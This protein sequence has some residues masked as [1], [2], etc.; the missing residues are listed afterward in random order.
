MPNKLL[1]Q[2]ARSRALD[3]V[4]DAVV[5]TD[6]AGMII[7][8][9]KGSEKL[10]GYSSEEA[11]GQPVSMLHV[12]GDTAKITEEVLTAVQNTGSW[13]G[14]IR[15]Q[16]KDGHIGWIESMVVPFFDE[17]GNMNGAVG[18]NRDIS[19]RIEREEHLTKLAH[20]D[21]LTKIPNRHLFFDRIEHLIERSR[22]YNSMFAVLYIDLNNFKI[23]NDN[24]GHAYGDY[25]LRETAAR[26]KKLVR[27]SD[28][29][30]RLGGDEFVVIMESIHHPEDAELLAST[31]TQKLKE[32]FLINK[33]KYT[34]NGSIG[35]AIYPVDSMTS[36]GLLSHADANM[37]KEKK[38]TISR[39]TQNFKDVATQR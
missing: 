3:L 22:R 14:E 8:W 6:M 33:R 19:D 31:I 36:D 16:H 17:N 13:T 5:T 37:Y 30:A 32:A 4:F 25:V 2:K 18:I 39:Q 10:Y 27:A 29:I 20:Y 28:T 23:I 1:I 15:M 12:P 35:I 38:S 26:L 34:V 11:L 24:E 7:D 21:Q 9:N